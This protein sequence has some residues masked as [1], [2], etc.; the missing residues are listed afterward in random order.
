[1]TRPRILF[2]Q[3][4][5]ELG[6]STTSLLYLLQ[7]L[8]RTRFDPVVACSAD[9]LAVVRLYQDEGFETATHELRF[10]E[11]AFQH[12]TG[13]WLPLWNPLMVLDA[14][15]WWR[16]YPRAA[17]VLRRV[18]S[19]TRC[20]LVH[21]NSLTLAP[22][23]PALRAPGRPVVVHVRESVAT[24]YLGLRRTWLRRLL[25][26][27]ADEVIYIS[28][29]DRRRLT[30]P[31]KGVLIP[32]FVDFRRFD[33]MLS[34]VWARERFGFPGEARVVLY[35]GGASRIKGFL[36]LI[37]A[38]SSVQARV[39]DV[40]CLMP[41]TDLSPARVSG[42]G[43]I[44]NLLTSGH[45]SSFRER[46]RAAVVKADPTGSFLRPMPFEPDVPALLAASEVLVFPSVAPHFAR[47]I[48][49]AGAMAKPAIGS[50][51]GGVEELIEHG[52]TGLLVPPADRNLLADALVSVL[53]DRDLAR[54]LGEG[55]Y[56][57]ATRTFSADRNMALL[58]AIYERLL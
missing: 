43:R 10:P 33:R 11:Y 13:R 17:A 9:A 2:V 48:V 47:P 23:A 35:L 37:A 55:A 46:A 4:A 30:G 15:R 6:G 18:A 34:P 50:R 31:A 14:L 21:L 32:N 39:P 27:Y 1:M 49:E 58:H 20:N 22:Y 56:E 8:D 3:H 52:N 7:G 29:D 28:A 40:V 26:R 5:T 41:G 36:T 44:F 42:R 24:G 54:R 12:T 16:Q 38:L 25:A 53:T 51:I 57:H 45:W 19:E